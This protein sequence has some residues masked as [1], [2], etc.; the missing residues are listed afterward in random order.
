MTSHMGSKTQEF[1]S[2]GGVQIEGKSKLVEPLQNAASNKQG[3]SVSAR[4]AAMP[5]VFKPS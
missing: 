5:P 2:A 3:S 1:L 4:G